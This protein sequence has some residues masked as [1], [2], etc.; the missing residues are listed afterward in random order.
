MKLEAECCG[1]EAALCSAIKLDRI[2]ALSLPAGTYCLLRVPTTD[3][4][5]FAACLKK[6]LR[7][8]VMGCFTIAESVYGCHFSAS[9]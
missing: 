9:I 2:N 8:C 6:H 7:Y 5:D 4:L 3:L 1:E